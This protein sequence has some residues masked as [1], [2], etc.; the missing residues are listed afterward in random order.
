MKPKLSGGQGR[1]RRVVYCLVPSDLAPKL[2]EALREHFIEEP[3]VQVVVER[4]EADR[5]R[6]AERRVEEGEAPGDEERRA[7]EHPAGRRVEERRAPQAAI[8]P[9]PLP[10][11]A[12]RYAERLRFVESHEPVGQRERDAEG[13]RLALR[14]QAGDPDA[15]SELYRR[16]F[17]PVFTYLRA[18][19][20]DTHEAEDRTQQVFTKVLEALRKY[21]VK[22]GTPFRA[23]LFRIARN[24]AISHLRKQG[25]LEIE[26][27]EEI[28]RRQEAATEPEEPEL[29]L[30]LDWLSNG[31]LIFL[32][33]RLSPLQRQVLTLRYRL[34]L[35]N[36]EI[37]KIIGRSPA[38]VGQ[39]HYRATQ[40]L[41]ERLEA[42]GRRQG[43]DGAERT[44]MLI[45]LRKMPVLGA[46][47][48]S[49]GGPPNGSR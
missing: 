18:A 3:D 23:W 6:V 31:D 10:R 20:K 30:E 14:A 28:E 33:E 4:R 26:P 43:G 22:E 9:L 12:R 11:R 16:Y 17:D 5:R 32:V 34:G 24:E 15:F 37:A 41:A 27:P 45:R 38:A 2:H 7:V 40:F 21:K 29:G 25:H 47:R 13:T 42:V 36:K 48:D 46:R 35:T 19:L 49:L 8:E 39:L 1:R 44:P